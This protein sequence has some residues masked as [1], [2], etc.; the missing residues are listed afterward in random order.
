[1]ARAQEV[2]MADHDPRVSPY[3][4]R[5]R[6]TLKEVLRVKAER[7]RGSPEPPDGNNEKEADDDD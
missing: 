4:L 3:L 5:R 6:R 7:E 1:M 2:A